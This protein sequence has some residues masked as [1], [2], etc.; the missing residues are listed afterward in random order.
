MKT[1]PLVKYRTSNVMG[2]EMRYK[3]TFAISI[4]GPVAKVLIA[5]HKRDEVSVWHYDI[6]NQKIYLYHSELLDSVQEEDKKLITKNLGIS[7][8]ADKW[9][10]MQ[11]AAKEWA[12]Q[13][14]K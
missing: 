9:K 13:K 3:E 4:T 12:A 6:K 11:Q 5:A 8:T 10:K 1:K 7:L 14:K 2:E